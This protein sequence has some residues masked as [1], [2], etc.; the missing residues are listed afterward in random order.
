MGLW[1]KVKD[2]AQKAADAAKDQV[3][4][5]DSLLNKAVDGTKKAADKAVVVTRDQM[6]RQ[7]SALNKAKASVAKSSDSMLGT[8]DAMDSNNRND[9]IADARK[10]LAKKKAETVAGIERENFQP[11][12]EA[13]ARFPNSQ[14]L[15]DD[16]VYKKVSETIYPDFRTLPANEKRWAVCEIARFDKKIT[17]KMRAIGSA[18]IDT[19]RQLA[20]GD[21]GYTAALEASG[22]SDDAELARAYRN[23]LDDSYEESFY[24]D[25][26]GGHAKAVRLIGSLAVQRLSEQGGEA[27]TRAFGDAGVRDVYGIAKQVERARTLMAAREEVIERVFRGRRASFVNQFLVQKG[28]NADVHFA[29]HEP[30]GSSGDPDDRSDD[31]DSGGDLGGGGDSPFEI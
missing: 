5:E 20:D 3:Q 19:V 15:P 2:A 7:D 23:W 22:L 24:A 18:Y 4:R 25:D 31:D 17:D 14:D 26:D 21:D 9:E 12:V 8:I 13:L 29:W 6:N 27:L 16:E 1:D 28:L 10:Y 11:E 30:D